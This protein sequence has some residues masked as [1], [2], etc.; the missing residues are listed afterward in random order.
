MLRRLA[1][2]TAALLLC[3][4]LGFTWFA[5][6][7][8]T[9]Q[10]D[11]A[12]QAKLDMLSALCEQDGALVEFD[13]DEVHLPEF[14][15]GKTAEYFEIWVGER[16]LARS[17]SLGEGD[18]PRRSGPEGEALAFDLELPDGRPGRALGAT[19]PIRD[20]ERTLLAN[21]GPRSVTLVVAVGSADLNAAFLYLLAGGIVGSV[22]LLLGVGWLCVR[23]ANR[24]LRPVDALVRHVQGI[25]D[26]TE[27]PVYPVESTPVELRPIAAGVNLLVERL[28]AEV[29][30]ERRTAANIA[31]E[32]RTPV[33][34]VL[35]LSEVALHCADDRE[36]ALEALRQVRDVGRDMRRLIGTLLE[37]ARLESG[38]TPL[39]SEPVE[40]A[41]LVEDCWQ[42]LTGDALAR[43]IAL[44]LEGARPTVETDRCAVGILCANLLGNAVDH[45]PPGT[46]IRCVLADHPEPS[47]SFSN[48]A[49]GLGPQDLDKLTEP[50]WRASA[51]REDRGHAGLGLALARRV[52]DLLQV[53]LTFALEGET[54]SARLRFAPPREG[55]RPGA[56]D[57]AAV[58]RGLPGTTLHDLQPAE[59]LGNGSVSARRPHRNGARSEA[60]HRPPTRLCAAGGTGLPGT[61]HACE[62]HELAV[63]RT[64]LAPARASA[65]LPP[66]PAPSR[67]TAI[68][69][70][71]PEA[72]REARAPA[73]L[74]GPGGAARPLLSL[75]VPVF[76]ELDNLQPL[77][78]RVSAALAGTTFELLLVDDGSTDGSAERIAELVRSD[79]RVR[80][81]YHGRNRGQTAAIATGI[82]A[83]RGEW[84]ATLDA[85]LQND[86]ADL[87]ELLA[88]AHGHDAVVGFR[89]RRNDAW[90]RRVSSRIANAVRDRV[91]GD[92]V[93]D[94]GCSLKLFRSEAIRSIPFFEGMHRFLPTLLRWHG[95][96]VVE[97]PVSHHPRVAGKSKYGVLNR[98]VPSTF[99]LCAVRWM[100]SR[101]IPARMP[102]EARSAR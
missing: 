41:T 94:T 88:A 26:P 34:E 31:H 68:P 62:D 27:A 32:L 56:P 57:H 29:Q 74:C 72:D 45:S 6:R 48:P 44:E 36:H 83:A 100:R 4:T 80:A 85:D 15:P 37:L 63:D 69:D 52:A 11:T 92:H 1:V 19:V 17:S 50:F 28:A 71:A 53:D 51:A 81:L 82:R 5:R 33:A 77:T 35:V 39:E 76:D 40:L 95:F 13:D 23:V 65:L 24:G 14:E 67:G 58:R 3:G 60:A 12:L 42:R 55:A 79:P 2:G 102:K 21:P 96:S 54:F 99:D 47:V 90:I 49:N 30:R 89:I 73:P 78:A 25:R 8:L 59:G 20:Y 93:T 43:D 70:L 86:P 64:A 10:F 9:R 18:L 46:R 87:F 91:T 97:R 22:G 7:L 98:L 38:Q 66:P 75:V 84:I 101:I 16:L 61:D